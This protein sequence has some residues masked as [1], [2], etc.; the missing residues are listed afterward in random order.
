MGLVNPRRVTVGI[1]TL[2]QHEALVRSLMQAES[3]P[4]GGAAR[5][6]IDTHIS[7]VILAGD[8]AYKLKK[9]LDL[10]FLDF[11]DLEARHQ[12]CLEELRLNRRLAPEIYLRSCA[13]TGSIEAPQMDGDGPTIDWAVCMRRFD[14]DAILSNLVDR[15]GS[16]LIE[17]LAREVARFHAVIDSCD[18][19]ASFGSPDA[20]YAPMAQNL[21]SI[22]THAPRAADALQA[23]AA[24]TAAQRRRLDAVLQTRKRAGHIRECH[25]DLHLG[26]VALIEGRPVVFD[27]IEFNPSLRWIDTISDTAFLT[28]DL[29][30]RARPDLAYRFLNRYLQD[31]GDYQGLAVLRFYEVYRALVRA[32]IAAIRYGQDDLD[33]AARSAVHAELDAYLAFAQGLTVPQQGAVII[34]R[35]V[36]GSGK[37]RLS[38]SLPDMLRAV[39][40]RSDLERKRLLGIAPGLDATDHGAY[41]AQLTGQTYSRL[42]LLARQVVDAGY[43]AVVDATFLKRTQRAR[44]SGLAESLRVPFVIIDCDA[45]P[46]VLRQR[47]LDR[48]SESDNVS[49]A[50]LAVLAM[51]LEGREPLDPDEA[52]RCIPV[53]PDRPL[54]V[55]RL[56]ALVAGR[57]QGA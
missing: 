31:G 10:G 1:E 42:E 52:A 49:D 23:L 40:L 24:W 51:Q 33:P 55:D 2:E 13:V 21:A 35:G 37:S 29:Q 54:A 50:D 7:S 36:S 4:Q 25:G 47:I 22:R 28:M 53:R 44:F 39:C 57:A 15:I 46:E 48:R 27:A 12:A 5:R 3:W 18:P 16:E 8:L 6:R 9:P 56:Q 43:I 17:S 34:M 32:K 38:R 14:P 26:N 30:E 19:A 20:A 45:A 11:V 41:S